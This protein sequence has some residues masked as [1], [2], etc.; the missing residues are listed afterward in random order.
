MYD[1]KGNTAKINYYLIEFKNLDGNLYEYEVNASSTEEAIG[2]FCI[3]HPLLSYS[4]VT[5]ILDDSEPYM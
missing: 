4:N 5:G 2:M 1:N 3:D